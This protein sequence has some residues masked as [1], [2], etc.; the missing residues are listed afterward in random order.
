MIHYSAIC[1]AG[2]RVGQGTKIWHFCHVVSGARVG[3]SCVVGQGCFIAGSAVIG[4]GVR[5]QN[6]VSVYDGVVLED[7]V[8][9]GPGVV[10]TNVRIPR[11]EISRREHYE[12]TFVERGA[13]IG[14]NATIRCGV[15]IGRYAMVGAGSVVTHDVP[16]FAL[17]VGNPA[18]PT[19]WVG[20]GGERLAFDESGRA[21]CSETGYD[22]EFSAGKLE[23]LPLLT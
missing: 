10:F 19:G 8:F 9:C 12:R 7:F 23:E 5:L 6:H 3:D 21:R 2:A 18:K 1:E 15:R 13:S 11:S 22:Y 14:A 17:V 4:N 20:R 16:A